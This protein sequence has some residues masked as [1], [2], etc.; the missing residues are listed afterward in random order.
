MLPMLTV[1]PMMA[2]VTM[3]AVVSVVSVMPKNCHFALRRPSFCKTA[4]KKAPFID[5]TLALACD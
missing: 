4:L 1:V 3:M 2:M 5:V